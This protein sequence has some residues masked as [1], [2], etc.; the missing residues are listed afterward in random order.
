MIFVKLPI[1]NDVPLVAPID[2]CCNCGA[3]NDIA[4]TLTDLRHMPYWGLAGNEI[5]IALPFPYCAS[6]V[7]SSRRRRPTVWRVSA[8]TALLSM[9]FGMGLMFY[10]PQLSEET[11]VSLV[12]PALVILSLAIVLSF[13]IFKRPKGTQSTCYQ[14]VKL[15]NSVHRWPAHIA[16]L[17]LGFTNPQY[18]LK[19]IA[20]NQVA[21]AANMLK[22]AEV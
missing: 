1:E 2:S 6:C 20:A 15:L 10:G 11:S 18:R 19:F 4:T 22:V 14:P 12:M 7:P 21:I 3:T 16:G 8:M 17:E 9:V 13:Y 5:A